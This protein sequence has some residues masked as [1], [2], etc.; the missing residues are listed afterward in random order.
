MHFD[1]ST[2]VRF[3]LVFNRNSARRARGGE[4]PAALRM[5]G[6]TAKD[7]DLLLKSFLAEVSEVERDNEV[8]RSPLPLHLLSLNSYVCAVALPLPF[9]FRSGC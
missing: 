7:E 5:M 1:A 9:D 2:R 4:R 6:E 8:L 3:Q